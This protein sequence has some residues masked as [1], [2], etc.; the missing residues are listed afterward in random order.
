MAAV[1]SFD[2]IV[3][4][5]NAGG[6]KTSGKKDAREKS[7]FWINVG[8]RLE[9]GGELY[10]LPMGIPLDKL[11]AREVPG[12]GTNNQ[13]FRKKRLIEKRIWEKIQD[14]MDST[15]PGDT[16]PLPFVCEFRHNL[17]SQNAMEDEDLTE[18]LDSILESI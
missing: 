13:A 2:D 10:Q 6:S 12:P 11:R 7:V 16:V 18:K 3:V 9:E 17:P 14:L 15:K 5:E 1:V 4:P 8:I